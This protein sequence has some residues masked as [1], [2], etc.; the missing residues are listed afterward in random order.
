M[1]KGYLTAGIVVVLIIA[2]CSISILAFKNWSNLN[3][4][5][6]QHPIAIKEKKC[7]K[8]NIDSVSQYAKEIADNLSKYKAT[9]KDILGL[10]SEGGVKTSYTLN[11]AEILASQMFYGE[12]GKSQID[13]Y[14][15]NGKVFYIL[16]KNYTYKFPLSENSS[17]EIKDTEIKDFFL[18]ENQNLCFWFD[19]KKEEIVDKDTESLVDSLLSNLNEPSD[20][21][22]A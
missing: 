9:N 1:K 19:N 5:K 14:F 20:I 4:K 8:V 11:G 10:S 15:K 6:N 22:R 18:D 7:E 16:K 3:T 13:F 12:T 17:G 2:V 21:P